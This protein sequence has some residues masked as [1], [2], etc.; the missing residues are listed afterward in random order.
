MEYSSKKAL[1]VV[2]TKNYGSVMKDFINDDHDHS[3]SI[4]SLSVQIFT[5]PTLSHHLIAEGE[6]LFVLFHTF[7]SECMRKLNKYG[8]LQ[9]ERNT[10]N[11]NFKRAYYIL[12]DLQYLLGSKPTPEQWTDAMR[13]AFLQGLSSF[14]NL[15]LCM[16]GRF[17]GTFVSDHAYRYTRILMISGMETVTRQVVQHMEFEPEWE[18]AFQLHNKLSPVISLIIDWCGSDKVILI[19]AFRTTLSKL[20]SQLEENQTAVRELADHSATCIQYDVAI[21]P[22]SIHLQVSRFLAGI[23]LHLEKYGLSYD[24]PEFQLPAKPSP[25]QIIEPVLRTQ[26]INSA[27]LT[28]PSL[29]VIA[30]WV[31][32]LR[33][34]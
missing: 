11:Q 30:G 27:A 9:F 33:G 24:S 34:F 10:A 31:R 8:K 7:M 28:R 14:L 3:F 18:A 2:F 5:T 23:Y 12:G 20:Q 25:E 4:A 29:A 21:K 16:Q 32:S 13:F 17:S 15:L 26:V 6:V 1:A 19:K 22:V